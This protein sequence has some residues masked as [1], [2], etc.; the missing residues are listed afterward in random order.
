MQ[1]TTLMSRV[2]FELDEGQDYLVGTRVTV[3]PMDTDFRTLALNPA[4]GEYVVTQCERIQA[5]GWK[6]LRVSLDMM[7]RVG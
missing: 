7:D 6:A 1:M 5:V 2:T 3:R 4:S